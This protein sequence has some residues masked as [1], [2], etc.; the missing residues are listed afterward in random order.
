MPNV[1]NIITYAISLLAIL[2]TIFTL[3]KNGTKED[4]TVMTTVVVKLENIEKGI[5]DIQKEVKDIRA[6]V[7]ALETRV[8]ILETLSKKGGVQNGKQ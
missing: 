7:R 8:T 5:A 1:A 3:V 4:S 6:D 2:I